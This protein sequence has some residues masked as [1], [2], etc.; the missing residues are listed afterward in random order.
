MP[1]QEKK[2]SMQYHR[3]SIRLP[4]YDYSDFG[5]YFVTICAQY[6]K[7]D[8]G[9]INNNKI[10]LT[11][12]GRIAEQYWLKVPEHFKNAKLDEFIVMPNHIHGIVVID[13]RGL[14]CQAPTQRRFGKPQPRSL[15][16]I[17]GSYK[18]AV[19][20]QCNKNINTN[21]FRWQCNYY[22][23]IIRNNA[24][25]NKIRNYIKNNLINWEADRN[26]PNNL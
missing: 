4:D 20:K 1:L 3:K 18:A 12:I 17:I 10:Q 9:I 2:I 6:W 25:L 22:E 14:T 8:F 26:N 15:S 13:C 11:Q 16:R 7:F 21:Y 19:T 24:E 5:H 23:R